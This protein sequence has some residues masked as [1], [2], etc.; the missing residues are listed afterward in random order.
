MRFN[1][2]WRVELDVVDLA[3]LKHCLLLAHAVGSKMPEP[4]T[5]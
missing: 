2:E 5:T 1:N 3:R 4:Y